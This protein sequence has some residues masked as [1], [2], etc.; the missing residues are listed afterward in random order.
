MINLYSRFGFFFPIL[1]K[2]GTE[3]NKNTGQIQ[4]KAITPHLTCGQEAFSWSASLKEGPG[5]RESH[6]ISQWPIDG[7]KSM[8]CK[9]SLFKALA[10]WSKWN[11]FH[12]HFLVGGAITILKNMT[13]SMGRIIYI[14]PIYEMEKHVW[15]HQPVLNLLVSLVFLRIHPQ[16]STVGDAE[17]DGENLT[18]TGPPFVDPEAF[19][20]RMPEL[21]HPLRCSRKSWKEQQVH[22][23]ETVTKER[24]H[25]KI[26][27]IVNRC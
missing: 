9:F 14:Y 11:Y 17:G 6:G 21:R 19:E 26:F 5:A 4:P 7:G 15:N 3:T 10:Q 20:A 18:S 25:G 13:S 27:V 24:I 16:S 8:P 1:P 23:R 2:D 12:D 22:C